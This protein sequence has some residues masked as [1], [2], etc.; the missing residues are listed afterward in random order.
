M[1][2]SESGG[3]RVMAIDIETYSGVD[4]KMAGVRPYTEAPDFDILLIAYRVDDQPTRIIDLA[5]GAEAKT[6]PVA[7]LD[8]SDL[9]AG[10]LQEFERLLFDPEIVKT[11]YNAAFERT[12]LA[13]YFGRPCPPEEWRC[14]MALA[15][16]LGLPGKLEDAGAALGLD[17]Q[18]MVEGKRLIQAFSKPNRDGARRM[19]EDKPEDWETFRRYCIR[20]VDV[21]CDIRD[22]LS[23]FPRP[24][25]EL[26]AW[27]LDQ[28]INDRGVALD[29]VLVAQAIALDRQSSQE[30]LEKAKV[31]TGLQNPNSLPLLKAWLETRGLQVDSLDKKA[32]PELLKAAPD[33][34]TRRV[35][36]LRQ[37]LAKTS[38]KKYEA[39]Q[40]G[41]CQ[42]GRVHNL[43]QF[44]GASRT[45]R[46][47]GRL[48]QVQN[49]PQ[50]KLPDLALA[51]EL[52]RG[53]DFEMLKLLFGSPAF[54]LSQLIRTAFIPSAGCRF[55]VCDYSAI[56]ARVLAWL[57]DEDWVLEEF[58][59]DGLIYEAT[60]AMMF[61]AAKDDIKKGGPRAD[62]RPKGK[63]ATLACGYQGGVGALINM[64]ALESGIPEDEL[65]SI[66]Q[67]WRR[68]NA[69]IVRYWGIVESA[70]IRAV[71]G[72]TVTITHGIRFSC[73]GGYLFITLPSGRRLAYVAPQLRREP[74]FDKLGLTYMGTDANK[75]WS[76][77]KT[78]GGKLTENITQATA[79]DCLRDAMTALEAAGYKIVFHVH[80]EVI[81]DVPIGQGSLEDVRKIMSRPVP[82]APGLPLNA[83]GFEAGFYMKD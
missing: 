6:Q 66:V 41:R 7:F 73:E 60:A 67:R 31:L 75:R 83:A 14:T 53:G 43:L 29:A 54:V 11:A 18:K 23:R 2:Y 78:Y 13:K 20:D 61:H 1:A 9:P 57:A 71:R 42:D 27:T 52:V 16:S 26:A 24:P 80:D 12:C 79:R 64:G 77:Q 76:R 74:Q 3:R 48:V 68:A 30:L 51:R 32:I 28:H 25:E 40:R 70:A 65:P 72:E 4:L 37:E 33:D 10:D 45:G 35:L 15:A 55:I 44:Y 5:A 38:V 19:P 36:Q 34:T 50:N 17:R 47:A 8:S 58:R 69:N 49:L 21:E 63:V 56:E 82:W 39:M 46:W 62:L 59:G 22:A 81:L